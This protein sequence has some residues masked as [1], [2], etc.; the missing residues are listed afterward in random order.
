MQMRLNKLENLIPLPGPL[1]AIIVQRE[2]IKLYIAHPNLN[3]LY[4]V[5]IIQKV[6]AKIRK[7]GNVQTV[8]NLT[9]QNSVSAHILL[10]KRN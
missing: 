9:L 4:V 3:V 2:D 6:S 10:K 1:F 7:I 8:I 5:K